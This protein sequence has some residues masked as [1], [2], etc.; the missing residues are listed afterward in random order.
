[1]P[2][3]KVKKSP[4]S[5]YC[6]R[7]GASKLAKIKRSPHTKQLSDWTRYLREYYCVMK[8]KKSDYSYKQAMQDCKEKWAKAKKA[9][10]EHP[11][12]AAVKEYVAK[13]SPR[14]PK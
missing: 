1:M 13:G 4:S 2:A 6:G 8:T 11:S 14:S 5:P 3:K 9:L 7:K 12:A 10:G